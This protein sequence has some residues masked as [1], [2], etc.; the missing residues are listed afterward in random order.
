MVQRG[1]RYNGAAA[2]FDKHT[3]YAPMEAVEMVK[4]MAAAKFDETVEAAFRLGIDPR[5]ADQLVRGTVGLP[6]GT[7]KEVRVAVFAGGERQTEAEEAGAEVVGGDELV[8]QLALTF[9]SWPE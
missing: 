8:E 7:G 4:Q 9:F 3:A 1:K 5:Q 6:H 2:A